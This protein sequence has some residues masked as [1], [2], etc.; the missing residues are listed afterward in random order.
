M[1]GLAEYA[2]V[3]DWRLTQIDKLSNVEVYRESTIDEAQILAAGVDK[4][5]LATGATW[6][7]DGTGRWLEEP[8]AGSDLPN[9]YTADDILGGTVPAG[10]VLIWD[11]DHYYLG[12]VM[13]EH[14]RARGLDVTLATPANEISTWTTHT[15]E[16]HRIQQRVLQLGITVR[17]GVELWSVAP[18]HA[19]VGCVYTERAE[20]VAAA[21]VVMVSSRQPNDALYRLLKDR[22]DITLIGDALAPG[23]IATAVYSGH[24]Y[25]RE[26]D[27]PV[28]TRVRFRRENPAP[29]P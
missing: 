4:V 26:L 11:D 16:Q 10:P 5:V 18:D 24:Q 22:I 7:R 6:R 9:V 19:T 29:N 23:T 21:S 15:E 20:H 2:R 17:T 3:R 12:G 8:V 25:A 13:A 1:P 27:A 14:L 28:A